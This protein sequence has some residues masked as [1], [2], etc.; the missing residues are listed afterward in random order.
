M[1]LSPHFTL[2][3]FELSETA[4]RLGIDNRVPPDLIPHLREL[5]ETLLEPIR[6]RFGM[7]RITSGY[8]CIALNRI[9]KSKDS[10]QHVRGEAADVVIPGIRPL[11]VCD[12][13]TESGLRYHQNIHEHGRWAHISIAPT[14]IIP[15]L[16][17]LTIDHEGTRDG[18]HEVR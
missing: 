11:V 9:L 17:N 15:R 10:S 6:D 8:R 16:Q 3:E 12:W 13:L 7:V 2:D 4:V 14:G 18:L 1:Q 5:C